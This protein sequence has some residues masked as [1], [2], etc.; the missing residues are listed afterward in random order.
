MG[1]GN[2]STYLHIAGHVLNQ[3]ETRMEMVSPDTER[4]LPSGSSSASRTTYTFGNALIGAAEALKTRILWRVSDLFMAGGMEKTVLLPGRIRHLR[5]GREIALRDLARLLDDSE[6]VSIY[7][8][9]A[10]VS[11][12]IPSRDEALKLHGLPHLI[13][14]YGAHLAC[15]EVDTLTGEAEV[16]RYLAVTDCGRIINPQILE[17][18]IHGGIAQ[19]LGYALLED[20]V[21][22]GGMIRTPDFATYIIPTALDL[23]DME[24]LTV[25]LPEE[26][27]PFGLKGAGEITMDGPLP[28]VANAVADACGIR[29]LRSPLTAERILAA[30][31]K[32]GG[33]TLAF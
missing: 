11:T 25:D 16:R 29:L 27:G 13:F 1:Q 28:A 18:Q 24:S 31:E 3:D 23:P 7:R 5:T 2:A 20:F 8:F 30:I 33:N 17:Q 6:R 26:T 22:E 19:G 14:S 32:K 9:Q 15:V 4:C 12:E 21:V 10:P